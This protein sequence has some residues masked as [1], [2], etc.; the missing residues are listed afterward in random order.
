MKNQYEV[1]NSGYGSDTTDRCL[2][3]FDKDVLRYQPQ[4]CIFQCGTNDLY[5]AMAESL[6]DQAA[7]DM[8]MA[9]VRDNT[10]EVAK[11]CWDAGIIPIIG[12]LIPRTAAACSLHQLII[13]SLCSNN[14]VL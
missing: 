3:R 8:K 14:A 12:T 7:L 11:R 4:Y 2:A 13:H 6:N 10:M 9:V 1:I 5:W